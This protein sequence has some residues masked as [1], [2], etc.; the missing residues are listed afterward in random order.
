MQSPLPYDKLVKARLLGHRLL[1]AIKKFVA[2]VRGYLDG[3]E[4]LRR[5]KWITAQETRLVSKHA[6][7][8]TSFLVKHFNQVDRV[9]EDLDALAD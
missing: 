6:D 5:C 7:V 2:V 9:G 8:L 1:A 4:K 3:R